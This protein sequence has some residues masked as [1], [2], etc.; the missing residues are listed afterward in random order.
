MFRASLVPR[1]PPAAMTTTEVGVV[2]V[3]STENVAST[4]TPCS[5]GL[6]ISPSRRAAW[7]ARQRCSRYSAISR[8]MASNVSPRDSSIARRGTRRPSVSSNQGASPRSAVAI[9]RIGLRRQ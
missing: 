4:S 9:A 6:L 8:T 1:V 3:V 2:P 5:V 7:A